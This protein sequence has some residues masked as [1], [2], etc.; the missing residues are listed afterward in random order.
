MKKKLFVLLLLL[1]LF[2][3]CKTQ[4]L[5]RATPTSMVFA[6]K[7]DPSGFPAILSYP[8]KEDFVRLK[9][10]DPKSVFIEKYVGVYNECYVVYMGSDIKY[11]NI[12]YTTKIGE[13]LFSFLNEQ[14]VFVYHEKQFYTLQEAYSANLLSNADL[15][16]IG[17][18]IDNA[19]HYNNPR[20]Q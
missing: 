17:G 7:A 16:S 20:M 1:L 14:P 19:F 5:I 8:I 9:H 6:P 15:Y 10:A 4:S 11:K 3:G 12:Q 18:I 2:M 13:Y